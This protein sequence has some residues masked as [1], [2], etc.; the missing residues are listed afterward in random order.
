MPIKKFSCEYFQVVVENNMEREPLFDLERWIEPIVIDDYEENLREYKEDSARVEE[1]YFHPTYNMW[2]LRFLRIRE[3]DNPSFTS[4]ERA[5]RYMELGDEYVSEDVTCLYDPENSILMIQKNSHSITPLGLE[6]YLNSMWEGEEIIRL[7]RVASNDSFQKARRSERSRSIKIRIADLPEVREAG[8]INRFQSVIG[9]A[10]QAVN[11]YD[12]PYVE[13]TLSMGKY[14]GRDADLGEDLLTPILNDIENNPTAFDKAEVK[15]I[16]EGETKSEF[17]NL[18]LDI[19]KDT[20]E[21]NIVRAE[22]L[23]F[24]VMMERLADKYCPGPNRNNRKAVIDGILL[25]NRR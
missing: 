18:F 4:R 25:Q 10:L 14:T 1:I 19:V 17:I 20:I 7:R 5:S 11:G 16:E 6:S 8:T 12:I 24:D 22:P 9:Q 2:F 23:R 15:V 13:L 3:Y 21:F